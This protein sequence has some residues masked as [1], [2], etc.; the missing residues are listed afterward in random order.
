[1]GQL[2]N[3]IRGKYLR[4]CQTFRN[5]AHSGH[6]SFGIV[7]HCLFAK[8]ILS[9]GMTLLLSSWGRLTVWHVEPAI[10]AHPDVALFCVAYEPLKH[11]KT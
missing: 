8:Y 7:A 6:Q 2:D 4:R 9:E 3:R 5:P 10:P 11:T 1:M